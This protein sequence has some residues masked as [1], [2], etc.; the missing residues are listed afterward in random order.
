MIREAELST[1][2][3]YIFNCPVCDAGR[4]KKKCAVH[5]GYN[6]VKCWECGLRCFLDYYLR[7]FE[8]MP[9]LESREFRGNSIPYREFKSTDIELP[10]G[11]KLFYEDSEIKSR[12][13]RYIER[14]GFNE[15][16][17]ESRGVGYCSEGPLVGYI[18]IPFIIKG[19]LR[20]WIG[21]DG[22]DRGG[23][24]Y[25]N[26]KG[27]QQDVMYNET[28]L[29][30]YTEVHIAE[31]VFD[32]WTIGPNAI[33][34]L[35]WQVSDRILIRLIESRAERLIISADPGYGSQA[36]KLASKLKGKE[37][38]I[39]VSPEGDAN[40]LGFEKYHKLDKIKFTYSNWMKYDKL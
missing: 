13:L 29:D 19:R 5:Y 28:A 35:G 37:V 27:V 23:M 2:G 31:G 6:Y 1:N 34:T 16:F 21:R 11:F 22:L 39:R 26:P 24:K 25:I 8:G 30:K 9:W 32:A 20:Y 12:L 7:T 4:N 38:Y 36:F 3:W 14:R 18:V 17:L 15:E 10:E 40:S 33:S